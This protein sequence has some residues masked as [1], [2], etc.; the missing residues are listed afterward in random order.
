MHAGCGP[1]LF[2]PPSRDLPLPG[3]VRAA[4]GGA[5]ALGALLPDLIDKP[6]G[7][8]LLAGSLD[9]GRLLAHDIFAVLILALPGFLQLHRRGSLTLLAV[10]AGVLL[11][12]LLDAMWLF[13]ANWLFPLLGPFTAEPVEDFLL[14]GLLRELT[15]PF[16]WLFLAASMPMLLALYREPFLR[17][18]P[19]LPAPLFSLCPAI[20]A[21]ALLAAGLYSVATA[22]FSFGNTLTWVESSAYNLL[23]GLLLITIAIYLLRVWPSRREES[24]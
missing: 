19:F 13:P 24:F 2:R 12:Q 6:V 16:E 9:Y 17:R 21:I 23:F 3:N 14:V 20:P 15:S 22:L 1:P 8:I 5:L 11:P 18:F 10:T 4:A 7:H